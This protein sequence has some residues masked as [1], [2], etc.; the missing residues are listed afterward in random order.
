M[1][2]TDSRPLVEHCSSDNSLTAFP[3]RRPKRERVVLL[4]IALATLTPVYVVSS[5][6]LSRLCLTRAILAGRLTISPCVLKGLDRARYHGGIYSDKAPGISFLAVPAATITRLPAS[7]AW[8]FAR[9]FHVWS[10]RVLT[11][12][13]A[14]LAV[15]FILGRVSEG[16]ATGSGG[17]VAVSFA[18]GTLAGGLAATT[19]D[20]VTA[21]A[22]GFGAF[23]LAWRGRPGRA[24]L[25]AGLA[26]T[27]EYQAALITAAV[28][29]YVLLSRRGR[30]SR[31]LLG[32]V[33]GALALAL[34]DW[35]AFGSPLHLSYGYV[36]NI[37]TQRQHAGFFGISW[38]HWHTVETVLLGDRGLLVASPVVLVA[39]VGL[40]LLARRHRWEAA[41]C[42]MVTLCYLTLEFCYFLPYGGV[43]PGPRFLIPALPFLA[44]GLAPVVRRFR[45]LS[46]AFALLSVLASTA[47]SLTWSWGST[48][49]YRQTVWG[50]LVR[51]LTRAHSRLRYDLASNVFTWA[52]LSPT[53]CAIAI[54]CCACLAFA[55]AWRFDLPLAGWRTRPLTEPAAESSR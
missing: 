30:P 13:I 23:A 31:Y 5:Q 54:A 50:E 18:L 42:A 27:V 32:I 29:V 26:V 25:L 44:L 9:D 46:A 51:A 6:D 8:R 20:Q 33:P 22:L 55:T 38:P 19:F 37:Y 14:F 36:A 16:I 52:G 21:A 17:P 24:G 3:W 4:L 48:L 15:V 39:S 35:A 41:T 11:S 34:Y 53:V 47:L 49:G 10:V 45:T 7:S 12:G 43:S 1:T 28:A 40:V 2:S